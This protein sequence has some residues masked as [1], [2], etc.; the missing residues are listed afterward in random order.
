[1]HANHV[2]SANATG[3]LAM[4]WLQGSVALLCLESESVMRGWDIGCADGSAGTRTVYHN[5]AYEEKLDVVTLKG[6][7]QFENSR[8]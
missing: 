4:Y 1:M 7:V 6:W 3:I 8:I 5:Q 2:L